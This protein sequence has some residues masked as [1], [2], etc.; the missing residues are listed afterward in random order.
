[1]AP[2]GLILKLIFRKKIAITVHGLDVTLKNRLY[3]AIVPFCLRRLD[4]I[5]CVS[6]STKEEC[7]KKEINPGKCVFIPNGIEMDKLLLKSG[8]KELKG[9]IE[10][11]F[12]IDINEKKVIISVGRLVKR[13]GVYWFIE[14]VMPKLNK[15]VFIVI[16]NG[17]EKERIKRLVNK[18]R[19]KEKIFLLGRVEDDFLKKLYNIADIFVM[20]NIKVEG[21]MEGFGIV[22]IEA[23][24]LG[25]PVI[26]SGIEGIKDAIHDGK[27]GYLVKSYDTEGFVN[28][29]NYI[30]KNEKK[31]K[32]FRLRSKKFT[33]ENYSWKK[34]SRLYF[35]EF[36]TLLGKK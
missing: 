4:K 16:G 14:H 5:I 22:A 9:S 13:K 8:K 26:A 17:P 15:V 24:S 25:I 23:S 29:I 11:K 3:Q 19:L 32:S 1:L 18:K 30:L 6:N 12:K 34:I 28:R 36:K 35:E 21:D 7:I 27:N 20:P 10:N 33:E 31:M 2:L